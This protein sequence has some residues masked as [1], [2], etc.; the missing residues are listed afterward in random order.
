MTIKLHKD[1]LQNELCLP[2]NAIKDEIYDNSRWSVHHSIVFVHND[3]FYKTGYSVGATEM[4]DESPW[5]Y[6]TDVECVE[7]KLVEK[8]VKTWEV[9]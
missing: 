9:C 8:L 4:Q 3:K 2:R 7:V 1:F 6:D 5:E